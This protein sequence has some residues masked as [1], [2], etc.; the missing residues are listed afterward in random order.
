MD[1]KELQNK[2]VTSDKL[3]DYKNILVIVSTSLTP[4]LRAIFL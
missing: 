4:D 2:I 3:E 1:D